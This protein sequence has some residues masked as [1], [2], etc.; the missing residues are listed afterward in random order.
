M[1]DN[2]SDRPVENRRADEDHVL[3]DSGVEEGKDSNNS[4]LKEI[5]SGL[6]AAVQLNANGG[7]P[8]TPATLG[9]SGVGTPNNT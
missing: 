2:E 1:N 5:S 3:T 9:Q 8:D 6:E 7:N 4:L